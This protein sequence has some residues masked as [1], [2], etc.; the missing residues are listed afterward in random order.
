MNRKARPGKARL[1]SGIIGTV[2]A[3]LAASP[4]F[5]EPVVTIT[6]NSGTLLTT[7]YAPFSIVHSDVA[8]PYGLLPANP[9][10][11]TVTITGSTIQINISPITG[12]AASATN[13]AGGQT[14]EL[15][16]KLDFNV[17]FDSPVL[18][19]AV[20]SE[21]GNYTVN[22]TGT[23]SAIA[24]VVIT[25]TDNNA[26]ITDG[27]TFNDVIGAGTWSASLTTAGFADAYTDY[28]FSIDNSLIAEA[29]AAPGSSSASIN[30]TS[31]VI[32]INTAAGGGAP[33]PA[34]LAVLSCGLAGL[35]LRPRRRC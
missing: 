18:L 19:Q 29:L 4:V 34:S 5:A 7:N 13:S 12:F 16:G 25:E 27:G 8:S 9:G 10:S 2:I 35:L 30:K 23:V 24:G 28:H 6:G 15:D 32:T 14:S 21:T 3:L 31:L 26:D 17:D 20:F 33:E 1:S 11:P 22:N